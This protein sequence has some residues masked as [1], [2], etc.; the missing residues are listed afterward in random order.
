VLFIQNGNV[1]VGQGFNVFALVG[2]TVVTS[3]HG[4]LNGIARRNALE[5]AAEDGLH[6]EA[7]HLPI[8]EFWGANEVFLSSSGG[9]VIP[10]TK[11]DEHH[12]SNGAPGPVAR[13]LRTSYFDWLMRD[14]LRTP[15]GAA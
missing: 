11:V 4:V 15:V 6:M 10:V 13:A 2:D 1:R 7:W 14:E 5:M 12:F 3:D 9:G 8:E